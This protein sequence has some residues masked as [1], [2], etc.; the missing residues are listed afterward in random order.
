MK[1]SELNKLDDVDKRVFKT[2]QKSSYN[3][4]S[5]AI[6]YVAKE[7]NLSEDDVSKTVYILWKKGYIDIIDED[8]PKNF[9]KYIYHI[10]GIWFHV[11]T[12]LIIV[13]LILVYMAY[14]PPLIYFR[15]VL[16]S[17]FVL[18]LPGYAL[19]EA[20]YPRGDE[21]E[22]LERLALSIGLSLALVPLVGLVLN[23]TPWGIRLTPIV[24]SL[25]ILTEALIIYS[26]YRKYQYF[27]LISSI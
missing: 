23:Y 14:S 18:Y 15:Y 9:L 4:L 13:T 22:P 24:T 3:T 8:T 2:L 10:E 21:L 5:E 20:L 1:D 19:I 25:A 11:V 6:K 17:L 27:R 7:L 16:G 12:T 26:L